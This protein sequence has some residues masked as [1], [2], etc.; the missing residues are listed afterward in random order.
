MTA[1]CTHLNKISILE[2]VWIPLSDGIRLA[3]KIWLP[4]SAEETPVPAILEYIP[5]RKR[6]VEAV[7]DSITHGYFAGKGYACVRVDLR[8]SGDSEGVLE[9]E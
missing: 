8:G 4:E 2:H 7:T 5:Y 3:A 6:D 1:V 9:D